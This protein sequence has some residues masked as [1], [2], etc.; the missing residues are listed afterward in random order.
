MVAPNSEYLE[1]DIRLQARD[2]ITQLQELTNA[3]TTFQER[4]AL[5][6][7]QVKQFSE[8]TGM[9][10][11]ASVSYFKE[12]DQTLADAGQQSALFGSQSKQGWM[13]VSAGAEKATGGINLMRTALHVLAATAIFEVINAFRQLFTEAIDGLKSLEVSVYNLGNAER[14]L[15]QS[16]IDITFKDLEAVVDRLHTKF[17]GL[18]SNV[19]IQDTVADIAIATK[20]L[21]LSAKQ[22]EQIASASAAIQLRNPERTLQD[23]NKQLL[24][25]ILSGQTKGIRSLGVEASEAAIQQKALEMGLVAVGQKADAQA[26]SLAT[27]QLIYD[28]TSGDAKNLSQ[29]QNNLSGV[30]Q[31]ITATWQDLVTQMAKIYGP[32]IITGLKVVLAILQGWLGIITA[33][34]PVLE[35]TMSIFIGLISAAAKYFAVVGNF[36]M[37]ALEKTNAVIDAFKKGMSSTDA[38]FKQFVDN[39]DTATG[40]VDN[41]NNALDKFDPQKFK[42]AIEGII[43]DS[44]RALD[45][46]NTD[47]A[48]KTE[49]INTKYQQKA[50][51]ALTK[52]QQKVQDIQRESANKVADIKQKAREEDASRE[53][54][55]Q[56]QLW[57]MQQKYLMDLEDALHNRDARAILRLQRQYAFDKE[58]AARKHA[59]DNQQASQQV[60]DQIKQAQADQKQKLAD[61]LIAYQR[62]LADQAKAKQRELDDLRVWEQR[63][64]DDLRLA[65]QRKLEDLITSW[66]NEGKITKQGAQRVYDILRSYFGPGGM[67]DALYKYMMQSLQ[68]ALQTAANIGVASGGIVVPTSGGGQTLVNTTSTT[69]GTPPVGYGGHT[70]SLGTPAGGLAEGGSYLATTPTTIRVG[71]NRP[72]IVQTTPIGRPGQ[73]LNK[74]FMNAS[75]NNGQGGG[76]GQLELG[77]TLSPDLESR[78]IRKTLDETAGVVMRVNKSKV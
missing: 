26:K 51:D 6:Q 62:E 61:A 37:S 44:Q 31:T 36:K 19:A 76:A 67:T 27:L 41:L 58:A 21:G 78:I 7:A 38:Y 11:K 50:E 49:D 15:S 14:A 54:K 66:I 22:I 30:T 17:Q 18:F 12:M 23:V 75:L 55:Y 73:D 65:E 2:A 9:S 69:G 59:L 39:A 29:Y 8:S 32:E 70:T 24:T 10:L 1:F 68:G 35:H 34:S 3:A 57:E 5:V 63:K 64:R 40:A 52:Y 60:T 47:V 45:D 43:T 77:V 42:E 46:L 56:L 28:A 25:A 48:R 72:E 53:A 4:V 16:G 13:D 71:E 20:D 74:L 33:L